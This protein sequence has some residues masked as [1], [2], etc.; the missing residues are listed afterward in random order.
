MYNESALETHKK[1]VQN[2]PAVT[3]Q[4]Q[5]S[6]IVSHQASKVSGC[7]GYLSCIPSV[8][9]SQS[10]EVCENLRACSDTGFFTYIEPSFKCE[11]MGE[12]LLLHK[13]CLKEC[14]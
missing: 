10:A 5:I 4:Q 3:E 11:V 8:P 7:S 12:C 13:S 9:S 2:A 14:E 1:C 6:T